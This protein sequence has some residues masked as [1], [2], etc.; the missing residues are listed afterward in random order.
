M[1]LAYVSFITFSLVACTSS[2]IIVLT[3]AATTT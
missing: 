3:Y 2:I 1:Q